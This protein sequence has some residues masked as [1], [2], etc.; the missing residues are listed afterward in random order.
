MFSQEEPVRN[1]YKFYALTTWV[2]VIYIRRGV[3][4]LVK[5]T[6]CSFVSEKGNFYFISLTRRRV[7]KNLFSGIKSFAALWGDEN[8]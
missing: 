5:K 3:Q 4:T 7:G 8:L 2:P 1:C 6:L